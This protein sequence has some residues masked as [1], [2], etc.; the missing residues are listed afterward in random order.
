MAH[1]SCFFTTVA[2]QFF[3]F[4]RIR[5]NIKQNYTCQCIDLPNINKSKPT[6][7]CSKEEEIVKKKRG[8][9]PLISIAATEMH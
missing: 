6:N 3:K 4:L 9:K 7:I 8:E 2:Y 1:V 5:L